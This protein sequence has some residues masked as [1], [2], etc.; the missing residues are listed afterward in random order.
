M[1]AT[2]ASRLAWSLWFVA[3]GSLLVSMSVS[4][5]QGSVS[6]LSG[7]KG[8][9]APFIAVLLF[10][11]A[12]A[13]VGALL[14]S[15]RPSNPIGWL[16]LASGLS[17]GLALY[18]FLLPKVWGDWLSGWIWAAGLTLTGTFGLL[19]FPTGRL[20]SRRWR[21]VTWLAAIGMASFIVGN[22]F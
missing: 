18:G 5:A 22:A 20:P 16:L 21:P 13:T 6:G 8:E 19:L 9:W 7:Q 12:L 11:P 14:G 17:Y 2:T 4:A 15:K 1:R 10:V 3:I